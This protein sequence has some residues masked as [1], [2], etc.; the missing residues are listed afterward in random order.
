MLEVADKY[1]VDWKDQWGSSVS[2]CRD[3]HGQHITRELHSELQ[4]LAGGTSRASSPARSASTRREVCEYEVGLEKHPQGNDEVLLDPA[5][6]CCF[7]F[8]IA[9][10]ILAEP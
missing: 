8:P 7:A 5:N 2:K 4:D 10:V 3:L 6:H 9:L 1:T